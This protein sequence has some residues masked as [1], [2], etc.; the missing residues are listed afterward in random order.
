LGICGKMVPVSQRYHLLYIFFWEDTNVKQKGI[1]KY[2]LKRDIFVQWEIMESEA[3]KKLSASGI[4]VLLRFLQKRTWDKVPQGRSRKKEVIYETTNLA[5]TYDEASAMGISQST[6]HSVLKRLI[7]LGFIDIA[8]Q[9]GFFGRDYSRFNLSDRWEKYGTPEFKH[10]EKKRVLQKG[11]D[12]QTHIKKKNATESRSR[13]TAKN[14]SKDQ[15]SIK[16]RV[17]ESCSY[18]NASMA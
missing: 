16:H 6:F 2:K 17:P 12:V 10:V 11:L 9:G 3:F 18:E 5:F 14:R 8:H 7:E 13:T 4:W 15:H 1:S